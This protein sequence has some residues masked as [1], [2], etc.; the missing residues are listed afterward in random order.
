MNRDKSDL[1]GDTLNKTLKNL[2][3][4]DAMFSMCWSYSHAFLP[5]NYQ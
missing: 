5:E 1:L 2:T 3:P 4:P